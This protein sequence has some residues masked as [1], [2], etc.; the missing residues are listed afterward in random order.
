MKEI[1]DIIELQTHDQAKKLSFATRYL[2]QINFTFDLS[3]TSNCFSGSSHFCVR[4]GEIKAFCN[5]LTK[6]HSLLVGSAKL[7]DNDSDA[8]V[9]FTSSDFGRVTVRGQVGGSHEEHFV[10]FEFQTDQT[11]ISQFVSDFEK[12]LA[13]SK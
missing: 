4:I 3:V 5:Q 6:M 8:F 11:C 2:V 1:K 9:I 13:G 7:C 10:R 12:L